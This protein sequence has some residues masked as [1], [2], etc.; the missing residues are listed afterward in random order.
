MKSPGQRPGGQRHGMPS[1]PAVPPW[2]NATTDGPAH[3]PGELPGVFHPAPS[4]LMKRP[5]GRSCGAGAPMLHHWFAQ[6]VALWLLAIP[7]ALGV[8]LLWNRWRTRRALARLGH[9]ASLQAL[10]E[11][12]G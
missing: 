11:P 9:P 8:L 12:P 4:G 6:P 3:A 5:L 2:R 10:V 1:G 7:P